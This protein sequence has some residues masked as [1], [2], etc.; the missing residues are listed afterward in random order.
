MADV[1]IEL[2]HNGIQSLLKSGEVE[3]TLMKL[4]GDIAN[5]AGDG[6]QSF[7]VNMPTRTIVRVSATTKDARRD[8]FKN[9]TL[10]KAVGK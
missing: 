3:E 1:R 9:N 2:D 5:R 7:P 8:N 4:G 6:Y 10:L